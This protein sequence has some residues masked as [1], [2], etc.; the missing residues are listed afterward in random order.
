MTSRK[1]QTKINN[2]THDSQWFPRVVMCDF[3]VRQLGSNQHWMYVSN[4][5]SSMNI[6]FSLDQFNVIYRLIFSMN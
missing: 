6:K 1:I 4:I 2:Q 3:M 5:S